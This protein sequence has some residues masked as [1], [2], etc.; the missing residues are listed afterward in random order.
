MDGLLKA[1]AAYI[2]W[3]KRLQ[4]EGEKK[5][6][7]AGGGTKT[8]ARAGRKASLGLDEKSTHFWGGILNE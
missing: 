6:T 1:R 5:E 2:S 4:E 8:A 3:R 7:K